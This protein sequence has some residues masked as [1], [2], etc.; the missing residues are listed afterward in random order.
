MGKL[1]SSKRARELHGIYKQLIPSRK[2]RITNGLY[3]RLIWES[4]G[5]DPRSN[6]LINYDT[7]KFVA[8][9]MGNYDHLKNHSEQ[10]VGLCAGSRPYDSLHERYFYS[11]L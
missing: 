3:N 11:P 10:L 6:I 5:P 2:G 7:I 4:M 1:K 8:K 9:E